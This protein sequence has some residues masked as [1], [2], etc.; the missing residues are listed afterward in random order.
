L[1]A[2]V[3]HCLVDAV[4]ERVLGFAAELVGVEGICKIVVDV[5]CVERRDEVGKG[6]SVRRLVEAA[7]GRIAGGVHL[8]R[9]L[10]LVC[11]ERQE[12][13]VPLFERLLDALV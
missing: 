1:R 2:Q 4:H 13:L 6:V 10:R 9:E 12:I 8:V 11:D 5:R 7:E 3:V